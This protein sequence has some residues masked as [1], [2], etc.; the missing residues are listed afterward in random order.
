MKK[1]LEILEYENKATNTEPPKIYT[2]FQTNEGWMSCFNVTTAEELKKFKGKT[3]CVETKES[4]ANRGTERERVFQNIEKCYGEENAA[5]V[6]HDEIEE[7]VEVV[8]MNKPKNGSQGAM[9]TSYAKDIFCE[10]CDVKSET[11]FEDQMN[12]S[13]ELVKQAKKAFE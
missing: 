12:T 7:K 10:I 13:I 8:K 3:V 5:L 4:I 6:P 11:P 9:F 2:R 1:N